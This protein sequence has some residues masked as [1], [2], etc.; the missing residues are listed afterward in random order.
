MDKNQFPFT[1]GKLN[2][3]YKND[4]N[5]KNV[6]AITVN[7][8][9]GCIKNIDLFRHKFKADIETMEGA[10]FFYICLKEGV[11]FMQIRSISN[12]VEERNTDKWDIPLAIKNLNDKLFEIINGL[13]KENLNWQSF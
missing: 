5:L 2:N 11:Q 12:Y 4:Y 1:D 10:A 13:E 7:T 8:T 3:T 9:H 6:S